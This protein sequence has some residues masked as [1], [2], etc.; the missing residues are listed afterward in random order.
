MRC[1]KRRG[2]ISLRV[3]IGL[4][5]GVLVGLVV[6]TYRSNRSTRAD[7]RQEIVCWGIT[8]FGDDVYTLVHHFEEA[9]PQYKVIISS[10]VERDVSGDGQRL[11]S[12]VAG[13]VP[14]DVVFFPRHATGEWAS[15]GALADLRPMI[16]RQEASGPY[17]I[18]LEEY[19]DWA[20]AESSYTP[21]GSGTASQL[22]GIPV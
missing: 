17:R 4:A 18:K 3:A 2:Q 11:L 10:S 16:E 7:G 5:L 1:V 8:Y 13:G 14:P 12:A 9:N 19:Y 15:R 20:L 6:W 22:C 21:P